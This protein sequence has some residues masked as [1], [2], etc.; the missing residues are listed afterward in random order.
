MSG[1]LFQPMEIGLGPVLGFICIRVHPVPG[2]G[3]EG[4]PK[5]QLLP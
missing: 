2:N 4:A 5:L 1:L 3:R